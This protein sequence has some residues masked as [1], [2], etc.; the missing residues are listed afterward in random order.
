M[1]R[2]KFVARLLDERNGLLVVT[3]IG[4][5]TYDVAACGDDPLNFYLW[6]AMGS[7]AMVGLG[8]AMARPDR[9]V[10]VITGDG[11]MLMGLG[12]LATIGVKQPKNLSVVVL[13]NGHYS[14]SGMQA[15]HTSSGI[16]LAGA[17]K[18]CQLWVETVSTMDRVD[19][20]RALLHAGQGPTFI[21]ARVDADDQKR[22]IP[23]RDGLAIK[24][25]FMQA[26]GVPL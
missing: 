21:H 23:S 17:A 4:S 19:E 18:A 6:S 20:L 13:D 7:T 9:R 3:G 26:A 11:D 8:L 12:S 14:A 16:D 5:S 15:S 10:A 24:H 25:R 2:R 22:I 1:D